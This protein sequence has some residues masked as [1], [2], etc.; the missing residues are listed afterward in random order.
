MIADLSM[1]RKSDHLLSLS[2]QLLTKER[3]QC[4]FPPSK[5]NEVDQILVCSGK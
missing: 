2:V 5:E 4:V 3:F 1:S